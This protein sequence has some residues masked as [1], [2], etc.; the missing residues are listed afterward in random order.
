[1]PREG[2]DLLLQRFYLLFE[3]RDAKPLAL[4]LAI[5]G[6][7]VLLAADQLHRAD[8]LGRGVGVFLHLLGVGPFLGGD[9]ADGGALV[10]QRLDFPVQ[11]RQ[12]VPHADDLEQRVGLVP[13]AGVEE[14][15]Q[16]QRQL[17]DKFVEQRLPGPL[18]G[19]VG[20]GQCAVLALALDDD[21]VGQRHL[22]V[23]RADGPF[24]GRG[25]RAVFLAAQRP[26]DGVQHAGFALVVVAAH[27]GQPGGRGLDL[28]GLDALD[29]LG[30]Q[31]G[32]FY[33]HLIHSP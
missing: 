5:A 25:G 28:H 2:I 23:G 18:S 20:D 9:L 21:T 22:Q 13:V 32:D 24:P 17:L 11:L 7:D 19:G 12:L 27:N 10:V 3:L 14:A 29:I 33:R 8:R 30:L 31:R 6:Q 16:I 4:V 26:G 1:M 15:R